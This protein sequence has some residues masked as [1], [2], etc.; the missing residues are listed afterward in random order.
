MSQP[1]SS[2]SRSDTGSRDGYQP[3]G[4][5]RGTTGVSVPIRTAGSVSTAGSGGQLNTQSTAGRQTVEFLAKAL[6]DEQEQRKQKERMLERLLAE[7]TVES[8]AYS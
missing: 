2:Y 8:C 7:E 1:R 3:L 6:Q 5:S 4:A